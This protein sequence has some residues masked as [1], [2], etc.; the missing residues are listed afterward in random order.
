M[1]LP[2]FCT[3]SR[4]HNMFLTSLACIEAVKPS[5]NTYHNFNFNFQIVVQ[6]VKNYLNLYKQYDDLTY[7]DKGLEILTTDLAKRQVSKENQAL[8]LTLKARIQSSI[9]HFNESNINYSEGLQKLDHSSGWSGWAQ[10]LNMIFNSKNDYSAGVS[11]IIA[12][13]NA[14]KST[15]LFKSEKYVALALWMLESDSSTGQLSSTFCSYCSIVNGSILVKFI[16]QLFS[17][18]LGNFGEA[19]IKILVSLGLSFPQLVFTYARM[20][21]SVEASNQDKTIN[22]PS[23][24]YWGRSTSNSAEAT[25][26]KQRSNAPKCQ[27]VLRRVRQ[28]VH[29]IRMIDSCS[30]FYLENFIES[31]STLKESPFEQVYRKTKFCLEMA[32]TE[33]SESGFELKPPSEALK[34]N[35]QEL[36][37][38]LESVL[39]C[40]TPIN[41]DSNL[42]EILHYLTSCFKLVKDK[43]SRLEK[44]VVLTD[45]SS[46]YYNLLYNDVVLELPG[47]Y[48][49]FQLDINGFNSTKIIKFYSYADLV[50]KPSYIYKRI[51]FLCNNGKRISFRDDSSNITLC[52]IMLD[53]LHRLNRNEFSVLELMIKIKKFAE[54]DVVS[55]ENTNFDSCADELVPSTLLVDWSLNTYPNAVDYF[56]FRKQFTTRLALISVFEYVLNLLP[57]YPHMCNINRESGSLFF[58]DINL[59]TF[60]MQPEECFNSDTARKVFM[61]LTPNLQQLITN[62]GIHGPFSHTMFSASYAIGRST[63]F[64]PTMLKLLLKKA[65]CSWHENTIEKIGQNTHSTFVI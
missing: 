29:S 63:S 5:L 40:N 31:L 2:Q 59:D 23:V 61:R 39:D 53:H 30:L 4:Q 50:V 17:N 10:L 9:G 38:E 47:E 20:H 60:L 8:V 48:K 27:M 12:Y 64:W 15:S 11:S 24:L 58:S 22:L 41:L 21:N 16:D 33:S 3:T 49:K 35:T 25:P 44:H 19:F 18:L 32:Y 62:I 46:F 37:I 51:H 57:L 26:T 43:S 6:E 36:K 28:I 14:A 7:L 13:M 42:R 52:D 65:S 55:E 54:S 1:V 34:N 56:M 45:H